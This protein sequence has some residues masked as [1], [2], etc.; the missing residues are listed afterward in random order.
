MTA[1]APLTC[2]H[3]QAHLQP[4]TPQPSNPNRQNPL[5]TRRRNGALEAVEVEG[6]TN[7]VFPSSG[8]TPYSLFWENSVAACAIMKDERPEDVLE[9]LDYYR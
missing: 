1:T 3:H 9:W 5:R 4:F 7:R 2:R 6:I 8:N